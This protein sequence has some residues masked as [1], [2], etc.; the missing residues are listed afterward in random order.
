MTT[1]E[2]VTEEKTIR[3]VKRVRW[4]PLIS[5]IIGL[6]GSLIFYATVTGSGKEKSLTKVVDK[7][8]SAY[9]S[10]IFT[11]KYVKSQT[12]QYMTCAMKYPW[13]SERQETDK[14]IF[15]LDCHYNRQMSEVSD[16]LLPSCKAPLADSNTNYKGDDGEAQHLKYYGENA[17]ARAKR[18]FNECGIEGLILHGGEWQVAGCCGGGTY[19]ITE[20]VSPFTLRRLTESELRNIANTFENQTVAAL[21]E[22]GKYDR[23][24]DDYFHPSAISFLQSLRK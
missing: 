7:Q 20:A 15:V 24:P 16:K 19:P 5:G 23:Q 22:S 1:E 4:A 10:K 12:V 3:P 14:G 11:P 8:S 17:L 18:D 21:R 9:A 13:N 6:T 2:K